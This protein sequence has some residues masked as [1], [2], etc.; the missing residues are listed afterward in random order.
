M[1]MSKEEKALFAKLSAA[2]DKQMQPQSNPAQ[3]FLTNQSL[4]GADFINK[5]D[6]RTLP[7]GMY[8]NFEMPGE[9]LK[10]YK[11]AL[12]SGSE[13]TFALGDN[14]GAGNAM[15]L[16]KQYLMDKFAR[17]TSQNYQNNIAQASSNVN[18]GLQQ[19]S[20]YETGQQQAVIG[21]LQAGLS[22]APKGFRWSSLLPGAIS[23]TANVLSAMAI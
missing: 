5:G 1:G 20:G 12:N 9:Q 3:Q 21:S 15:G 22:A 19:A 7:K 13:G 2:I 23:G 16:N 14:A 17:D 11:D 6:F 8:F 10:K 4:Q 18:A